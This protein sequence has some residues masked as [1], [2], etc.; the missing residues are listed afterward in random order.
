MFK[1]K[2]FT[3]LKNKPQEFTFNRIFTDINAGLV[4]AFIAI[5]L[6]IAFGIASGVM[7]EK[8]LITAVVAGFL[9]SFFS[10]SRVQIGGP[11]G[12]FAIIVYGIIRTYG[13][14]GLI[15]ATTM[16]GIFLIVMGLLK[17]GRIIRY[18]PDPITTGFTNGIAVILFSTQINDFLGLGLS[19]IP[20]DFVEKWAL[21]IKNF[22]NINTPTLAMGIGILLFI[23]FYPKK[24]RFLPAPLAALIV[25]TLVVNFFSLP[26]ATIF[27]RFGDIT[28]SA[29]WAPKIPALNFGL[30]CQ[31][32]QPALMIAILAG[33]ESLL[34]AVIADGMTGK[35]HRSNT[36]LIA[37]GIANIGSAI[38][39]GIP[40]TGAIVRTA[41]NVNNGGRT[42]IAGI[43]HA[44]FIFMILL[45]FMKYIVLIPMVTLAS[46]LFM[47]AFR[48]VD[49]NAFKEILK[50]PVS[51]S[52]ILVTT[53][54]LTVFVSLVYAIEMGII[55][56][57]LLFMKRMSD[58]ANIDT[59]SNDIYEGMDNDEIS[60]RKRLRDTIVYEINGPFF[61]GA[62]S[63]FVEQIEKIRDC[64]VI[65]LRMRKVPAM[66][67]T[68]YH[69]LYK[70]Y[71]K[72]VA[73]NTSLILCQIQKQPLRVLKNYGFVDILGRANFSLNINTAFRKAEEYMRYLEEYKKTFNIKKQ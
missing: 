71:K 73:T 62:A 17:F 4:V 53:F 10:G 23:I 29:I 3:I 67:A 2:F 64:K 1:P 21:Y 65:I 20:S 43:A 44:F 25:S 18:I 27:S 13:T 7:P 14:N 56:A 19:S 41:A 31:L 59:A 36:E 58:I 54:V 61:F 30:I 34:S 22:S 8:G 46:I 5:P 52:I 28:K 72:C 37:Q 51:D 63:T 9:I 50:A 60:D 55:L 15:T 49:F 45:A 42:P 40:A 68:G 35:K 66:D 11:T 32:F 70:I 12:A 38:F 57:S 69:A 6:S 39:G 24:F 48:M 16:A 26:I 33:I 47:S